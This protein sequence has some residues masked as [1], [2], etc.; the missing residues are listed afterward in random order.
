RAEPYSENSDRDNSGHKNDK[1]AA[2]A[3][4]PPYTRLNARS[5]R[6]ATTFHRGAHAARADVEPNRLAVENE[7]LP[8]DVRLECPIGPPLRMADVVSKTLGLA[9]D[10]TLP[11]HSGSPFLK[12]SLSR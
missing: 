2:V 6:H 9:A 3:D 1:R 10:L 5:L 4:R 7:A 8:V 12:I 11:G